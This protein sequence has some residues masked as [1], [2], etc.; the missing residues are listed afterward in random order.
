MLTRSL[1]LACLVL[2]TSCYQMYDAPSM[3]IYE[4]PKDK[5]KSGFSISGRPPKGSIN[6]SAYQEYVVDYEGLRRG[7]KLFTD[8]CLICHMKDGSGETVLAEYGLPKPA[9]L[10]EGELVDEPVD[11]IYRVITHG[12]G[13]MVSYKGRVTEK[14]RWMVA[15][16][17]KS[18]Q[19][20]LSND[21]ATY[22]KK[23]PP[24]A[25]ILKGINQELDQEKLNDGEY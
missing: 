6:H 19:H 13:A 25:R 4:L 3:N 2:L 5:V 16:Y 10:V 8:H 23:H 1:L 9:S 12:R 21:L 22:L 17:V 20:G 14:E 11:Y 15:H 18:M 24:Q 7:K